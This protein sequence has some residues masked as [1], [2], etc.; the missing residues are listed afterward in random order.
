MDD[1]RND[2]WERA[3]YLRS[4]FEPLIADQFT[5]GFDTLL[6]MLWMSWGNLSEEIL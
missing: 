6:L 3:E 2:L 5:E 1:L 4:V